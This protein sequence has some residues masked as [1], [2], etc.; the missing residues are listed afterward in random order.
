MVAWKGQRGSFLVWMMIVIAVLSILGFGFA[1]LA[2]NEV[3]M[4]FNQQITETA[5]Q[6]ADGGLAFGMKQ[7]V[8]N[9]ND[10]RYS[11]DNNY[12][13]EAL[14]VHT[15]H[16]RGDLDGIGEVEVKFLTLNT[17]V[18]V[19]GVPYGYK[20]LST[21]FL[22]GI[23]ETVSVVVDTFH[24]GWPYAMA[25]ALALASDLDSSLPNVIGDVYLEGK[26]I[27]DSA[28][29]KEGMVQG[30]IYATEE[31]DIKFFAH[32][33]HDIKQGQ[34]P[35]PF[36]YHELED[37]IRGGKE[38]ATHIFTT[39]QTLNDTFLTVN[40]INDGAILYFEEAITFAY[41]FELSATIYA[42]KRD[43]SATRQYARA[44]SDTV[45]LG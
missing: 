16:H 32:H 21:S 15:L 37:I 20:I 24:Q 1:A 41:G 2:N 45:K 44:I 10:N 8:D 28:F 27:A 34:E 36:I 33:Q 13:E 38:I 11:N 43:D 18:L 23:E 29:H 22:H 9:V 25:D 40:D 3:R 4:S 6:T 14:A 12:F 17:P 5:F 26:L 19:N 39:P 42:G 35:K 7:I 31:V 30:N